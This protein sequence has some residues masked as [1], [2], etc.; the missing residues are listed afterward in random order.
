M[1]M[2]TVFS[3]TESS[4]K[5]SEKRRAWCNECLP[6]PLFL[7]VAFAPIS[8]GSNMEGVVHD[9]AIANHSIVFRQEIIVPKA[10]NSLYGRDFGAVCVCRGGSRSRILG[11]EM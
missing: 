5:K 1:A 9:A 3:I 4:S 2:V 6:F 8:Q 7:S 11:G 10:P